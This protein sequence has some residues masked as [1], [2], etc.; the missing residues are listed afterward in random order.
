L[1]HLGLQPPAQVIAALRGG[2]RVSYIIAG[3]AG[4]SQIHAIEVMREPSPAARPGSPEPAGNADT[5]V[6]TG[7]DEGVWNDVASVRVPARI[8]TFARSSS[9][10]DTPI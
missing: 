3:N 1:V 4:S 6:A 5:G 9:K 2:F 8:A 10:L 7:G